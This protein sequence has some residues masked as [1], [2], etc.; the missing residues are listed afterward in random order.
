M[1][2]DA[3][4]RPCRVM[5][6]AAVVADA[7]RAVAP[8]AILIEAHADGSLEV[9]AAGSPTDVASHP[10]AQPGAA[11][12]TRIDLPTHAILPA[13]VN[14]HTHLDLTHVG[15]VPPATTPG[16]RFLR[17]I[18]LVRASR[19]QDDAGIRASVE[20]GVLA[21][22]DGGVVAV[23]D[24]AGATQAR[25][26]L[27]AARA[28]N[29]S[30]LG[31]VSFFEFFAIG[32]REDASRDFTQATLDEALA[33]DSSA[34]SARVRRVGLS[35]HATNTVGPTTLRWALETAA[36]SG[37]PLCTHV[38]ET[39]PEREL[40]AHAR[41][42]SRAFL[43]SLG[44]WNAALD[45]EL[46]QGRTS[47]AHLAWAIEGARLEDAG[48]NTPATW[49]LAHCNDVTDADLDLLQ[50]LSATIN[51][52]VAY[53]PRASAYFAAP[54]L[55]GPHRYREMLDRGINVALGTDS[56]INLPP[57]PGEAGTRLSPIWDARLLRRR[58]ATDP[59]T[60]LAMLTTRAARALTLDPRCFTL[61]GSIEA[62]QY[63]GRRAAER[64][65][66]CAGLV[67][68]QIGA[69]AG[70]GAELLARAFDGS[71]PP[72][73]LLAGNPCCP[74]EH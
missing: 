53:C 30:D 25:P 36:A 10:G 49:V 27:A 21:S 41:G 42:P 13:F 40:I 37:L 1:G 72:Q 69:G 50:A 57:I 38:A 44:L 46:G 74:A 35:P 32:T 26:N 45:Q 33:D 56:V 17:F 15:Y 31:G 68:V 14:A 23:G 4:T 24:I 70:S 55:I 12:P 6:T 20:A 29:Q 65:G 2:P 39:I 63:A 51:L 28:L 9:L 54:E 47:I 58:D 64:A 7:N 48:L 73:L 11:G 5:Y 60:L 71:A 19:A 61:W 59:A 66:Q 16:E 3:I 67:G 62:T 22:R 52:T 8:G 18:E 34:G 43:E